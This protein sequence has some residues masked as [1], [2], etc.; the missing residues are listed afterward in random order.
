MSP[1]T[2]CS[3][4]MVASPIGLMLSVR[5]I[6]SGSCRSIV[7]LAGDL[8]VAH[9]AGER[10]GGREPL[11]LRELAVAAERRARLLDQLPRLSCRPSAPASRL[12]SIMPRE[13]KGNHQALHRSPR[14]S[15]YDERSIVK[16]VISRQSFCKKCKARRIRPRFFAYSVFRAHELRGSCWRRRSCSCCS[17]PRDAAVPLAGRSERGGARADARQPAHARVRVQRR[18]STPSSRASYVAFHVGSDQLD[19]DAAAALADAYARWQA[20][21]TIPAL[22]SARVHG[23]RQDARLGGAAAAR[24]RGAR[25]DADRVAAASCWPRSPARIRASPRSSAVRHRRRRCCSLTPSIP[26]RRRC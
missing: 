4:T 20:S 3:S 17:R 12:P 21:A 19:A 6:L 26:E 15:E 7:N 18:S 2:P 22:V 16:V 8:T 25:A 10:A 24:S 1:L 11:D 9:L 23:R 14:R 13:I 5:S